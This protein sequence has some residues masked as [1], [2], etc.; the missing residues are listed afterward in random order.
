MYID[1][2]TIALH[3]HPAAVFAIATYY[4]GY[5][6]SGNAH[7]PAF[8]LVDA[9]AV[10]LIDSGQQVVSKLLLH[11]L[12]IELEL[13]QCAFAFALQGHCEVLCLIIKLLYLYQIS[14]HTLKVT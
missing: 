1:K 5:K 13:A 7:R 8:Y 9:F 6:L 10:R 2:L 4:G 11:I 12:G 3:R 14:P